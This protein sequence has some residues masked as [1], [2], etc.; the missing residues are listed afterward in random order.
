MSAFELDIQEAILLH[1][2]LLVRIGLM[3][4]DNDCDIQK[5]LELCFREAELDGIICQFLRCQCRAQWETCLQVLDDS[6]ASEGKATRAVLKE[7]KQI[8]D[9]VQRRL[10]QRVQDDE[11][12]LRKMD[13]MRNLNLSS[14]AS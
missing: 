9:K 12:Y 4:D 14:D 1:S 10:K 2:T 3:A 6:W 7:H 11:I 13:A 8:S 5:L